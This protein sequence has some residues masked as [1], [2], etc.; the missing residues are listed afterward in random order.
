MVPKVL[1]KG[2]LLTV[3]LSMFGLAA[4]LGA[5]QAT[6]TEL[7]DLVP[8][9]CFSAALSVE[10]ADAVDIG[11]ESGFNPNTWINKACTASTR[12]F[13][14]RTVTDTFT[15][16]V[17]APPGMRIS[18]V[19]Y[20]QTGTRFLERSTYW[21]ASGTG[22]LT[23]NGVP[24]SFSFTAPTLVKSVDLAGQDLESATVSVTISLAAGRSAAFPRVTA[25]PG[26]ATILVSNAVI[27][28]T[29]E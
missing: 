25:P 9:R 10:S 6:F 19:D 22:T 29:Y 3:V 21:Q 16:T 20:E 24:L 8:D 23:V 28:V 7:H 14:S 17:T 4:A 15:L 1:V 26:S 13:N 5:Q 27:R 11:I 2:V 12:A 18:R